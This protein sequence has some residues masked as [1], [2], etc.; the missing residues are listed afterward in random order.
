M[1][2]EG[3]IKLLFSHI[4]VDRLINTTVVIQRMEFVFLSKAVTISQ[5]GTRNTISQFNNKNKS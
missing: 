2:V 1:T 3:K 5:L 4:A